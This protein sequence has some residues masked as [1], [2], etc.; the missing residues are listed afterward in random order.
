M[1]I[2]KSHQSPFVHAS[3]CL[4]VYI[5]VCFYASISVYVSVFMRLTTQDTHPFAIKILYL[6]LCSAKLSF[7]HLQH[8]LPPGVAVD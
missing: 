7:T 2:S 6:T 5:Y 4:P 3:V 8:N 1:I